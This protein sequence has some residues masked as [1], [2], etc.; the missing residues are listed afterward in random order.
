MYRTGRLERYCWIVVCLVLA[1]WLA[2]AIIAMIIGGDG[3]G[4]YVEDGHYFVGYHGAYTEVSQATFIYSKVHLV[5]SVALIPFLIIAGFIA[6]L[7]RERR[8]KERERTGSDL[9]R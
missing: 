9:K 5:V 1:N 4:G 8:I 7:L 6:A 3:W 2:C